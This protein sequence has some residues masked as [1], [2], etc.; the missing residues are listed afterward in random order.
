MIDEIQKEQSESDLKE[1][2]TK[3]D[4]LLN[5]FLINKKRYHV[6]LHQDKIVWEEENSKSGKFIYVCTLNFKHYNDIKFI[7]IINL[8]IIDT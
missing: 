1:T 7:C 3:V 6:L 5:T 2:T 8:N 4:I